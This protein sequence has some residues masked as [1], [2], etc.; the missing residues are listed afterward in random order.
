M[1]WLMEM[2]GREVEIVLEGPKPLVTFTEAQ[3]L[4]V[5]NLGIVF[6]H[7]Q[8]TQFAPWHTIHGIREPKVVD[9]MGFLVAQATAEAMA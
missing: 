7:G 6:V 1:D 8:R 5:C 3:L 9:I 4:E 2:I